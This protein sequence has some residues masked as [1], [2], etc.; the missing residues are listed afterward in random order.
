MATASAAPLRRRAGH[1]SARTA[2]LAA[3]QANRPPSPHG[4][5]QTPWLSAGGL[6]GAAWPVAPHTPGRAPPKTPRPPPRSGSLVFLQ[7]PHPSSPTHNPAAASNNL[8]RRQD[9]LNKNR[10]GTLLLPSPIR[11]LNFPIGQLSLSFPG[12]QLGIPR[13]HQPNELPGRGGE[14]RSPPGHHAVTVPAEQVPRASHGQAVA[15]VFR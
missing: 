10:A 12:R 3:L 14:H 1:T 13:V 15:V 11:R 7:C 2:P 8:S 4:Q 5:P 9:T 6:W